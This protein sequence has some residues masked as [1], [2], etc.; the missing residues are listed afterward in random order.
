MYRMVYKITAY[1]EREETSSDGS[2]QHK[3]VKKVENHKLETTA[4]GQLLLDY[5][6]KDLQYG[7]LV[8]LHLERIQ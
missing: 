5:Y 3:I 6:S 7:N 2:E 8:N 4:P 1:Y